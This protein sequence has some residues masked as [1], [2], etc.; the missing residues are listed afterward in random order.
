MV[1]LLHVATY[2]LSY[3]TLVRIEPPARWLLVPLE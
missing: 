3:Y 2:L 1:K